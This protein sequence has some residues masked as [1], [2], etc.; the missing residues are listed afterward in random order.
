MRI[1]QIE[2]FSRGQLSVV[3][4]TTDDE[5]ER[6]ARL[7]SEKGYGAFKIRIGKVCGHDE[8]QWPGR[9][10]ALV[11]TVR[12]ALGD[13]V[14]L[15]VDGNSCYTPPRAIEVGRMLEDNAWTRGVYDPPL[16]IVEGQV[17]VP[18]GAGW[19]VTISQEWLGGAE[20]QVSQT[21]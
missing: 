11:P 12:E 20:R 17:A 5:A 4:V 2:T 8:D 1:Q 7:R 6:L 15:L 9:T 14:K 13:E 16:E 19:G 10:E 3:R 18:D 21:E